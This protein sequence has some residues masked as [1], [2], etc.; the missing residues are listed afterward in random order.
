MRVTRWRRDG[1]FAAVPSGFTRK[2]TDVTGLTSLLSGALEEKGNRRVRTFLSDGF[3]CFALDRD[4]MR[5]SSFLP[6][7]S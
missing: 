3:V 1:R 2:A 7:E 6:T 4:R 5:G